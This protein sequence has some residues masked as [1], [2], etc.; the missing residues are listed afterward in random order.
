M[1]G[2]ADTLC[3]PPRLTVTAVGQPLWKAMTSR[4]GSGF[5]EGRNV[6]LEYRWANGGHVKLNALTP[7]NPKLENVRAGWHG[8]ESE[9]RQATRRMRSISPTSTPYTSATWG[10]V[11]PYLTKVRMRA[12][13]DLAIFGAICCLGLLGS[14]SPS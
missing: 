12:N 3:W 6:R 8:P 14:S 13:C 11:M 2:R 5:V 7:L 4:C 10:A 1:V 9:R